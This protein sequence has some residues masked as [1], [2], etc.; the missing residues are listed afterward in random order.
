MSRRSSIWCSPDGTYG[1]L[2][3]A[4]DVW[5]TTLNSSSADLSKLSG[6][7]SSEERERADRFRW[8]QDRAR[9]MLGRIMARSV[10][11]HCLQKPAST[12]QLAVDHAGKPVVASP[13]ETPPLHFNIS[14]AGD[15]VLL[16]LARDRRVGVDV[17]QISDIRDLNE[18]AARCFSKAEYSRLQTIPERMRPQSFYRCWTLKEAYLKA[19]G[20][21]LSLPLE[22]FDVAFLPGEMPR[23]L[24][25]RFDPADAARWCL[26]EL[27]MGSAYLA[28]VAIEVAPELE[29]RLWDW[30]SHRENG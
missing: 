26:R 8:E 3:R 21:G 29:L 25:T 28:A 6:S 24:E 20:D 30:P 12:I 22:S 5:R 19:R 16:A 2:D 17:E 27:D 11:G 23:L 14:H 18:I 10:L 7:L 4:V 1:L 15:Y 13:S 9:F